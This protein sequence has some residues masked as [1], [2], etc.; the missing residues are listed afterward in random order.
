MRVQSVNNNIYSG[1]SLNLGRYYSNTVSFSGWFGKKQELQQ[2]QFIK[3]EKN[4]DTKNPSF[5]QTGPVKPENNI[6]TK[7]LSKLNA[8]ELILS[9]KLADVL[10]RVDKNSII[11]IGDPESILFKGFVESELTNEDSY[12]DNPKDINNVYI[13]KEK[14]KD[15]LIIS[16]NNNK[17]SFKLY[18]LA[19]NL[20][21][22]KYDFTTYKN[23]AKYGDMIETEDKV[24]I[25]LI[26]TGKESNN[27]FYDA[28]VPLQEFFNE[29]RYI[30]IKSRPMS[31]SA[32]SSTNIKNADLI[33]KL[34][35]K[36]NGNN[37]NRI[38]NI[39][40][41]TFDD[42]AGMD[43]TIETVKKKILFPLLY[44]EAF[45]GLTN[46][47]TIFF[48][49]PGTGKTLLA[50]AIIGEAKKRQNQNIHFIK[51]D[52]Q[53]FER[54]NF[55][56]TEK[57]WRNTFKELVDNQ[58]SILFI[59][60]LDTIV[61]QRREGSNYV[62]KN[63]VTA[64]LLTLIDNLEKQ[65]ARVSIIATTNRPDMID[66]AIKRSGRLGNLIE[67]KKPDE[68]GC[69]DILNHYLKNKR[70]SIDFNREEFAKKLYELS[71]SGADITAIVDTARD[72]MYERAG[73]YDKMDNGSY[74]KTD[75]EEL[76]YSSE[77]FELALEDLKN[78]K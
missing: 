10:H 42:V 2:D 74:R 31:D 56:E 58:P 51:V 27:L 41:R 13:I 14:T 60:E 9:C 75:L 32:D 28:K 4:T 57:L 40:V 18:G 8:H 62:G 70:V 15:P 17:D 73:I 47:G 64:Q 66:K 43:D 22:S 6:G 45:P 54:S 48:G 34:K 59:D 35:E 25:K 5:E 29:E 63:G 67:I 65:H 39:P 7:D 38:S 1:N 21:D 11:V 19:R 30:N 69:L 71:C 68:K 44:P 49:E 36:I 24:K 26:K 53:E 37:N 55:G 76:Q 72:K 77:D 16:L 50:L 23:T 46:K 61:P 12:I 20:S 33:N 52:S 3:E 78:S